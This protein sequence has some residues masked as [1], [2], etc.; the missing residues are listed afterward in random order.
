M[1][2]RLPLIASALSAL[3][4]L[5]ACGSDD[6]E[7]PAGTGGEPT[8]QAS[9]GSGKCVDSWN[10]A[11]KDVRAQA[12]LSHRGDGADVQVGT[13]TGTRFDVTGDSYDS[14][15][16]P[17]T[18]NVVVAPGDCVAVDL[19]GGEKETNWV[20]VEAKADTPGWH[21]IP[22]DGSHELAKVPQPIGEPV[23]ATIAGFGVDAKLTP[24][25]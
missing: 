16:S 2:P 22:E 11:S 1:N 24:E 17:T 18:V 9:G 3:A 19:T 7:N 14:S 23:K 25:Q 20:M 15:G 21:F 5:G 12:S 8:E 6:N 13:Y 10:K 4:L